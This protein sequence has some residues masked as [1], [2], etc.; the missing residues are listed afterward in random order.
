ML[1]SV[2]CLSSSIHG[3]KNIGTELAMNVDLLTNAY[4]ASNHHCSSSELSPIIEYLKT[5]KACFNKQHVS[6][7]SI[8]KQDAKSLYELVSEE[9]TLKPMK[10]SE[11]IHHIPDLNP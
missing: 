8:S 1:L 10:S 4:Y 9:C 11:Y 5:G 7:K 2:G 6:S 3:T